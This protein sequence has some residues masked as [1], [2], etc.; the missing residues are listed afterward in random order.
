VNSAHIIKYW[1]N[2]GTVNVTVSG[3]DATNCGYNLTPPDTTFSNT[4]PIMV[5]YHSG[6][7]GAGIVPDTTTKIIAGLYIARPPITSFAGINLAASV[8]QHPLPNCRLYY[9]QVTVEPQK[10][11]DY[12]QRNEIK[13]LYLDLL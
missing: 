3:P 8:L 5:N 2:T 4:C 1:V 7:T 13:K 11:I 12:V 9:S 10:S 6:G